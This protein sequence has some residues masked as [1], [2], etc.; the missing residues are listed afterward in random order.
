MLFF[1]PTGHFEHEKCWKLNKPRVKKKIVSL[2]LSIFSVP[3]VILIKKHQNG[4][5]FCLSTASTPCFWPNQGYHLFRDTV[6]DNT[7]KRG[8]TIPCFRDAIMTFC[9]FEFFFDDF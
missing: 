6:F 4:D 5:G 3:Y 8:I 1:N 9:I 7:I 2:V